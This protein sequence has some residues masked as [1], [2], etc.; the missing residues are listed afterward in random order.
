MNPRRQRVL[1]HIL[2]KAEK[3]RNER[4][5][6]QFRARKI[7]SNENRTLDALENFRLERLNQRRDRNASSDRTV[8]VSQ[9]VTES[10]FDSRLVEAIESQTGKVLRATE[11]SDTTQQ[12][13]QQAQ[14]RL[15]AMNILLERQ[16]RR[17]RRK[18]LVGEQKLT[19]ELASQKGVAK[20]NDK[21]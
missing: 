1:Q 8:T 21:R 7:L 19:D 13:L 6:S 2:E 14:R 20:N 4:L 11:A 15:S 3:V 9:Q 16:A 5:A 10:R 12:A 17:A 18:T